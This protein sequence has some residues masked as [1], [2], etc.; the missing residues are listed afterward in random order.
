MDD[1]K[2]HEITLG[3][4]KEIMEV[5][6]I[7]ESDYARIRK[8]SAGVIT[9]VAGGGAPPQDSYGNLLGVGDGG[10]ATPVYPAKAG[11]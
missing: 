9:T 2:P 1:T 8:V 6:A 4:W 3:E 10:P 11:W 5:P 7:R